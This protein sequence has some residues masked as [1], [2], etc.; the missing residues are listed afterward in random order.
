MLNAKEVL[1]GM[2]VHEIITHQE[3][4]APHLCAKIVSEKVNYIDNFHS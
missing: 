3:K 2:C 1:K 4:N